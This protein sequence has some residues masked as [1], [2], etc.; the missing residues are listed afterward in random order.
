M[1]K[2]IR[3]IKIIVIFELLLTGVFLIIHRRVIK[4]WITGGEM[5][6]APDWHPN[7]CG[8]K[9]REYHDLDESNEIELVYPS[10]KTLED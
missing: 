10:F 9:S 1:K 8:I 2:A 6:K 3:V 7:F 5:P 4:A